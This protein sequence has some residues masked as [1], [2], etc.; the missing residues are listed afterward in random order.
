MDATDDQSGSA[1]PASIGR[2]S[3]RSTRR[4]AKL[5]NVRLHRNI[6]KDTNGAPIF[7]ILPP[8]LRAHYESKMARYERGWNASRDPLFV[9]EAHTLTRLYRQPSPQWLDEAIWVLAT[10]R[11]TAEHAK[12]AAER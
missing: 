12:R 9:T 11:R 6:P 7:L 2:P 3:P 1:T 10:S 4:A 8:K 5:I